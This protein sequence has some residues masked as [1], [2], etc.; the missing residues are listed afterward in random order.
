MLA[1]VQ[2]KGSCCSLNRRHLV[3][4]RVLPDDKMRCAF[5]VTH[6]VCYQ[7]LGGYHLGSVEHGLKIDFLNCFQILRLIVRY[8]VQ[9][10]PTWPAENRRVTFRLLKVLVIG[11]H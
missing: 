10:R 8:A 5:A 6:L 4:H 2:A 9:V 1:T 3:A 11:L 7:V